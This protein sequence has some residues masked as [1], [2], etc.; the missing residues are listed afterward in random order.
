[1][2]RR[3]ISGKRPEIILNQNA[4]IPLYKQLYERL[5]SEILTEQLETGT[6]LPSTRVL[7][8]ELGVSRNTTALAYEMLLLEGYIESR[9]GDSTKVACLQ[10]E[11]RL[12]RE[13]RDALIEVLTQEL[14]DML[15]V[16][17]SEAGLHL[18]AWLPEGM[19]AEQAWRLKE[20]LRD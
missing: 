9:V 18:V 8:I 11:Q 7:A 19:S 14:G 13:R 6:R 5:R 1:M 17:V 3:A 2:S 4:P 20:G 12:Y 10:L 15:D 16:S